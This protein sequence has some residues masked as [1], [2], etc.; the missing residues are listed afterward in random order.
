[1]DRTRGGDPIEAFHNAIASGN[2]SMAQFFLDDN[3]TEDLINA[4]NARNQNSTALMIAIQAKQ[5]TVVQFLLE[6]GAKVNEQNEFNETALHIATDDGDLEAVKLLCQYDVDKRIVNE[7]GETALDI[8]LFNEG[9]LA[10]SLARVIEP[11][12]AKL[13]QK[14]QENMESLAGLTSR[15]LVSFTNGVLLLSPRKSAK[16]RNEEPN[17][18]L[19]TADLTDVVDDLFADLTQDAK[20]KEK[21]LPPLHSWLEKKQASPPYSWQRRWVVVVDGHILW[22]D[23]EISDYKLPLRR[24]EK[25]RW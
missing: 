8:A 19:F 10:Q 16:V 25:R 5:L 23:R 17:R 12:E 14:Q 2:E 7:K 13:K 18:A 9:E 21:Q 20:Q 22:A 4:K 3:P 11:D 15:R 24:N 6:R 1:M